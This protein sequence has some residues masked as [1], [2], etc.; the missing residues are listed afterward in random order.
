MKFKRGTCL[1]ITPAVFLLFFIGILASFNGYSQDQESSSQTHENQSSD[2][3]PFQRTFWQRAFNRSDGR[4]LE[5][6][7]KGFD[8][9]LIV[10]HNILMDSTRQIKE[11]IKLLRRDYSKA[12]KKEV[13]KDNPNIE[14]LEEAYLKSV[15]E[16]LKFNKET[17]EFFITLDQTSD[18]FLYRD[19]KT[20]ENYILLTPKGS[21]NFNHGT[22]LKLENFMNSQ[23]RNTNFMQ[24]VK[25]SGNP[26]N[27]NFFPREYIRFM[28]VSYSVAWSYCRT[29][30]ELE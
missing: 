7:L 20:G 26:R 23:K 9:P 18:P 17:T 13:S 12:L 3:D 5:G 11:N 6:I 24:T 8:N 29:E 22:L 10:E 25:N 27:I 28:A 19:P 30:M 21:Q 15:A 2:S 16:I 14:A 1:T 4:I